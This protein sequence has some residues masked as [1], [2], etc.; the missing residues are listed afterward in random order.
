[1]MKTKIGAASAMSGAVRVEQANVAHRQV[2]RDDDRR[3]RD[4]ETDQQR[5]EEEFLSRKLET[6]ERVAGEGGDDHHP[7]HVDDGD[8]EAVLEID[9]EAPD[10]PGLVEVVKGRWQ[11]QPVRASQLLLVR[12]EGGEPR[13]KQRRNGEDEQDDQGYVDQPSCSRSSPAARHF[14][15]WGQ[16]FSHHRAPVWSG[17]ESS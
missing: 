15:R 11:R 1:M 9:A 6:G 16:G 17:S 3:D 5:V 10:G 7:D 2:E 12:L 14:G 13:E 8:D 4:R